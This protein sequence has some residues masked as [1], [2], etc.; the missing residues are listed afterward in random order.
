MLAPSRPTRFAE[1]WAAALFDTIC[2]R[3]AETLFVIYL[4]D[5]TSLNAVYS[6]CGRIIALLLWIYVSGCVFILD[7]CL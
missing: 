3:A 6:A 2:L 7:A 1:V 4:K 5:F